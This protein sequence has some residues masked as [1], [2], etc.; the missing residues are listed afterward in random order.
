M[1]ILIVLNFVM[2]CDVM[3]NVI[4]INVMMPNVDMLSVV[5]PVKVPLLPTIFYTVQGPVL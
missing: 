4:I 3:L 5:G 1:L 2:L